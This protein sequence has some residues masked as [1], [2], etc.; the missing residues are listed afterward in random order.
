MAEAEFRA[1]LLV[2]AGGAWFFLVLPLWAFR[3]RQ[4]LRGAA[5][6]T[7]LGAVGVWFLVH[8]LLALGS[9]GAGEL[10]VL[11]AVALGVAILDLGRHYSRLLAA[12]AGDVQAGQSPPS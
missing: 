2:L 6:A 4:F 7:F 10:L 3:L 1:I 8:L 5:M 11:S 9:P 12:P